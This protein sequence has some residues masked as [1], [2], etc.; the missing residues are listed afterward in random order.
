MMCPKLTL[1][2][3]CLLGVGIIGACQSG[4]MAA[5]DEKLAGKQDTDP[6]SLDGAW[7]QVPSSVDTRPAVSRQHPT[8]FFVKGQLTVE[9]KNDGWEV[10][11]YQ[12]VRDSGL[13]AFDLNVNGSVIF[14]FLPYLEKKPA[15]LRG[16]Y[17]V[18][19]DSMQLCL[20]TRHDAV[21][22]TEFPEKADSDSMVF[23]FRRG[24]PLKDS[25][26]SAADLQ[27][28]QGTWR[29][30]ESPAAGKVWRWII[31]G[32]EIA[33]MHGEEPREKP[34]FKLNAN[35]SPKQIFMANP[36][37]NDQVLVVA[38]I[39][40]VEGDRLKLC[41]NFRAHVDG[42]KLPTEFS[43]VDSKALILVTLDREAKGSSVAPTDASREQLIAPQHHAKQIQGTW[44]IIEET[45]WG[46]KRTSDQTELRPQVEVTAD[47]IIFGYDKQQV[48]QEYRYTLDS[49]NDPARIDLSELGTYDRNVGGRGDHRGIYSLSDNTLRLAFSGHDHKRPR[50][51]SLRRLSR[52]F[53]LKRDKAATTTVASVANDS[54]QQT[55]DMARSQKN[56]T[57]LGL[58]SYEFYEAHKRYPAAAII[59]KEGQ[60]V[61]SWR[62]ALLPYLGFAELHKQFKLDE[63]WDAPHNKSLLSKMPDVYAPVGVKTKEPF[64]TFY[65]VFVGK[66]TPFESSQGI[67]LNAVKDGSSFTL[68]VVEAG[69]PVLWTKPADLAFDSD[70]PLPKL[71]GL[72]PDRVHA[73]FLDGS[74]LAIKQPF[75]ES[76]FRSAI[77]YDD[78]QPQALD[79]K[80]LTHGK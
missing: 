8:W 32:D 56:L 27:K 18:D 54:Q 53:V 29:A 38:G 36:D 1:L 30:T 23:E 51:F 17:R 66:R 70:K 65:Q 60:P 7:V 71:G 28:L 14:P 39:Y 57:R 6:N 19:G 11:R 50:E 62:V 34:I 40:E 77:T 42:F 2:L 74:V 59:N 69:E 75:D 31:V 47:R 63:P 13:N 61:L 16:I 37:S 4:D 49:N 22:P 5:N 44:R 10:G 35:R 46:Q 43:A 21:R 64:Q 24:P 15:L 3:C 68:M 12:L 20:A 26:E 9:S 67:Q 45:Q 58:A 33:W 80:R 78:G 25:P 79:L 52:T 55:A 73:V 76:L 72:F 41:L 48:V